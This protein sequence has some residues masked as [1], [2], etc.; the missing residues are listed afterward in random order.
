MLCMYVRTYVSRCVY[1]NIWKYSAY[2]VLSALL[3]QLYFLHLQKCIHV[4]F[5]PNK[6]YLI[7]FVW[8][9]LW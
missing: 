3:V 8:T 2:I 4:I 9:V 5:R 6:E 7:T 1:L